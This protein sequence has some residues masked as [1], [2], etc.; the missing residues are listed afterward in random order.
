M[1]PGDVYIR[2]SDIGAPPPYMGREPGWQRLV[3]PVVIRPSDLHR[4]V[5]GQSL[6]ANAVLPLVIH[7][8]AIMLYVGFGSWPTDATLQRANSL[9][10]SLSV[11][12]RES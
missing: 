1:G 11:S 3:V 12:S 8:R 9:L 5:E 2:I 6:P 4:Y 7:N 10:A